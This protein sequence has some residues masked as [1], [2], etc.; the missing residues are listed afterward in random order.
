MSV[1]G[2]LTDEH[3]PGPH[4]TV[5][6]SIGYDVLRAKD[7]FIEG[8][9]D[10]VLLGF[11]AETDRVVLTCDMRFTIADGERVTDHAGVIYADQATLQRRPEDAASA[12]DRIVTTVPAAALR[13]SEFYLTDWL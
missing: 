10:G 5:L 12:V 8:T 1:A 13:G 6:R 3:V 11:A 4:I 2:V 7:E 9:E